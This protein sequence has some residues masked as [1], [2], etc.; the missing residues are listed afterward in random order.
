[1]INVVYK[2]NYRSLTINKY[3]SQLKLLN[4]HSKF[5]VLEQIRIQ[6]TIFLVFYF[7][8]TFTPQNSCKLGFH[9]SKIRNSSLTV[10]YL[11]KFEGMAH[12]NQ[13]QDNLNVP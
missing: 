1:M 9:P 3:T 11:I 8:T 4:N 2:R 5:Y 10:P 7:C 13:Q 6:V 12:D